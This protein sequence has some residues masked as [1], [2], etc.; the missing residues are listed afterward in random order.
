[1]LKHD[2]SSEQPILVPS[3]RLSPDALS[4]LIEEFVTRSGTDYGQREASLAEKCAA[5]RKQ[6]LSGRA[7]IISEPS[8]QTYNIV[9]SEDIQQ[10]GACRQKKGTP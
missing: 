5:L 9:Q 7:V 10:P 3:E 4:G 6:L 2:N 8:S 1:M